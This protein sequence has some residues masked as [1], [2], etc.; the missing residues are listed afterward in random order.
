MKKLLTAPS[1]MPLSEVEIQLYQ[2][3]LKLIPEVSLN[4]MAVKVTN[5]PE[6]FVGWCHE[7]IDV[8]KNRINFELLEPQQLPILKKIQTTLESGITISQLKTLR[9]A[10]WPVVAES[11]KAQQETLVLDEQLALLDYLTPLKEQRLSD[12][13]EEDKLAFAGKHTAKHD[14]SIYKFDVEWFASTKSAKNLHA[15]MSTSCVEL[16][17][18]LSHIPLEGDVTQA[19]YAD[20]VA[21]YINAFN[22]LEN[23]K[24]T[25]APA[26]RL[27]AM[28]RPDIFTPVT[29][30]SLDLLCQSLGLVKLTNRDF[31]RYWHEIVMAIH[32]QPWYLQDQPEDQLEATI[33]Q[34]R[35]LIP[36]WFTYYSSDAKEQSNYYRALHKPK[37]TSSNSAAPKRRGK[38][39]AEVLVD[40]A[41]SSDEIPL[42]IKNMRDS[43]VS[44][45]EKG[46]SVDETINLMRTIFG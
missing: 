21:V 26:T 39:S 6:D 10:P 28:R 31:E 25:L 8:C 12:M 46:R 22:V 14:P 34:Y 42:H 15:L 35:A 23:E 41:L 9:I 16:D 32:K 30:G 5:H 1:K 29:S 45:V 37:R 4:L 13:I 20:F 44:E 2:N 33:W 36:C 11:I 24:A 3:V 7:L 18:A 38:E 27:L 19:Q 43:I 17:D 40:R